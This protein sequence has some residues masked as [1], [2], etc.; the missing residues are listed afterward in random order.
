MG[1]SLSVRQ[2]YYQK[3]RPSLFRVFKVDGPF[4]S[5]RQG[6][7][8][9]SDHLCCECSKVDRPFSANYVKIIITSYCY[10]WFTGSAQC[11]RIIIDLP[12]GSAKITVKPLGH[13]QC[14]RGHA[15]AAKTCC[16][17]MLLLPLEILLLPLAA[18]LLLPGQQLTRI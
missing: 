14:C 13:R 15:A 10:Y 2:G 3:V 1:R 9:V 11:G 6:L 5:A 7:L 4:F 16:R 12:P 17:G 8:K 18:L